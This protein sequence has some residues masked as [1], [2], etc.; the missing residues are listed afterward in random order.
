MLVEGWGLGAETMEVFCTA[1]RCLLLAAEWVRAWVGW[2][3]FETEDGS[4][5][6]R[7]FVFVDIA[8]RSKR[9]WSRRDALNSLDV[10]DGRG[11]LGLKR[12]RKVVCK[13]RSTSSHESRAEYWR[14]LWS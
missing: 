7:D 8:A 11:C 3:E 4:R 14:V 1:E 5:A 13:E 12:R 9:G 2:G 10:R 6:R